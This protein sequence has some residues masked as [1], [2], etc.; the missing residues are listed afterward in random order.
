M[1]NNKYQWIRAR[2]ISTPSE[3][4]LLLYTI[5]IYQVSISCRRL[6]RPVGDLYGGENTPTRGL[7]LREKSYPSPAQ[8]RGCWAVV[9]RSLQPPPPPQIVEMMHKFTT[10]WFDPQP[11]SVLLKICQEFKTKGGWLVVFVDDLYIYAWY[12]FFTVV[13]GFC[14]LVCFW[15]RTRWGKKIKKKVKQ[16]TRRSV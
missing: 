4:K 10:R 9:S 15:R 3:V 1:I 7:R 6:W 5:R 13:F 11:L 2:N 8:S 12:V 14:F 16:G